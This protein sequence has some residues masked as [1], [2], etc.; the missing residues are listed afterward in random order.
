MDWEIIFNRTAIKWKG[1]DFENI[2]EFRT[3]YIAALKDADNCNYNPLLNC[4]V[5]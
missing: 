4:V 3:Q 5:Y 2:N 1:N